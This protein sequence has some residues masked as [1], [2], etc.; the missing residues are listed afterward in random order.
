MEFLD[1]LG[2]TRV[3]S[4][5]DVPYVFVLS[6]QKCVYVQLQAQ[7]QILATVTF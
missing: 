5:V 3:F 4:D 6:Y 1:S 2:K 7:F